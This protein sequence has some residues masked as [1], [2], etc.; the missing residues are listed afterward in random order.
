MRPFILKT[1]S[2][3]IFRL[4]TLLLFT[5]LGISA[6]AQSTEKKEVLAIY[7]FTSSR[8]YSYD[9]ALS[10]G[11]AVEAGVIRSGRFTVVERNRF[12]SLKEEDKFKEANTTEIIKI[13]SR[14]GAK[15]IIA[16]HVV[17]VSRGSLLNSS[18]QITTDKF[19]DISLSFKIIDVESGEIKLSEIISGRG[20]GR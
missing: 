19:A 4:F 10:A 5:I 8:D 9:Y 20:G 18:G 15:T 7:P 17:G 12:G 14:L 2:K 16:G 11:N 3:S 6:K 13:A 1:S